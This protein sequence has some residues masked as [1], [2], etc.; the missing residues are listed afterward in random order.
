MPFPS[1]RKERKEEA[2]VSGLLP[3]PFP[4]RQLGFKNLAD[5]TLRRNRLSSPRDRVY[6]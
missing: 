6:P 5:T 3:S 4:Q 2:V 1:E